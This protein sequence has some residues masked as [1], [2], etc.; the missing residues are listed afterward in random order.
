MPVKGLTKVPQGENWG[1]QAQAEQKI[2]NQQMTKNKQRE[3]KLAIKAQAEKWDNRL[4]LL[5]RHTVDRVSC[6]G[7][8]PIYAF[9]LLIQTAKVILKCTFALPVEALAWAFS[10][11][12]LDSFRFSGAAKDAIYAG[13]LVDRIINSALAVICAPPKERR[14][15]SDAL[16]DTIEI[17][18]LGTPQHSNKISTVKA[19]FDF[20]VAT[21]A[22]Y[23]KQI[24]RC[25]SIYNDALKKDFYTI[26]KREI[27]SSSLRTKVKAG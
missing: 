5:C 16:G 22:E 25:E 4:D 24:F 27:L 9:G 3:E 1:Q 7:R 2:R 19:V 13:V 20:A 18:V 17:V 15:F 26:D 21:R 14:S 6:A 23:S 8:I 10:T 12:K 11:K